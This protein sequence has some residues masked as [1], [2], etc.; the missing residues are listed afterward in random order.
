M[1]LGPTSQDRKVWNDV[2][3]ASENPML[4][5]LCVAGPCTLRQVSMAEPSK[6]AGGLEQSTT[7]RARFLP[8]HQTQAPI[9]QQ[10]S[11]LARASTAV[12]STCQ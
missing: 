3:L 2:F 4:A 12:C 5:K 10:A 11:R 1:Q 9:P 8:A 6:L 7:S